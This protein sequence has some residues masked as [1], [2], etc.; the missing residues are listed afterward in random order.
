MSVEG[1]E[2]FTGGCLC[3]SVRIVVSGRPYRVGVCHCLDCRKPRSSAVFVFAADRQADGS[4]ARS[5]DEDEA[6]RH[7][8]VTTAMRH[9]AAAFR[10]A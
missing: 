10:R 8:R 2:R 7:P 4:R 5:P 1:P 3:G 9:V 6:N